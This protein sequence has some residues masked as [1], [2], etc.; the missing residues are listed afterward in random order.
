MLQSMAGQGQVDFEKKRLGSSRLSLII[1]WQQRIEADNWLHSIRV[2]LS[3]AGHRQVE[4]EK[5]L[6][7]YR[8]RWRVRLVSSRLILSRRRN[9]KI[10]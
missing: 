1:A 10:Q 3:K 4:V 2:R 7:R 9:V 6:G 8:L 5:R